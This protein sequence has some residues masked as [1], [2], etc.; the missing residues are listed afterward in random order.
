MAR[1]PMRATPR[2]RAG[3]IVQNALVQVYL[4][5]TVTP[6]IDMFAAA[7]GG[8]AITTLLTNASGE[9]AAY[10]TSAKSV[11]LLVTD[12]SDT[13]FYPSDPGTLK[14]FA[15]FTR[16]VPVPPPP[17]EVVITTDTRTVQLGRLKFPA[18]NVLIGTDALAANTAGTWNTAIGYEALKANTLGT[19]QTA[20]G[21]Q[22]LFSNTTGIANTA[23]GYQALHYN[24]LGSRNTAVGQV[25]LLNLVGNGVVGGDGD[26]NTACGAFAGW[27]VTT[28]TNNTAVG[29]SALCG[30]GGT[31]RLTGDNNT[32]VGT[33]AGIYE[34]GAASHNTGVGQ[35]ALAGA[36]DGTPATGNN[37]SALG[38]RALGLAK[39]AANNVGIGVHSLYEPD[40]IGDTTR[41]TLDG[42]GNTAVGN[43][44]GASNTSDPSYLTAL[45]YR[46]TALGYGTALGANTEASAAG[47]VALGCDNA[48][49]GA[50]TS[51]ANEIKVGTTLHTVNFAGD[52]PVKF[53]SASAAQTTVGAAGAASALPAT[54]T[55]YFKV[56]DSAGTTLVIPAYAA[57]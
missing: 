26:S 9:V 1:S 19:H 4:A 37:N 10:F 27:G 6:V 56:K 7:V 25:A 47:S 33:D 34:S 3:N 12:N 53:N 51:V 54:P 15:P 16:T 39:A 48:G 44:T 45:G 23:L 17:D 21:F 35:G 11:D 13:A 43:F 22:A 40:S 5:G 36:S 50:T 41:A 55:K 52:L 42:V 8:L 30:N 38:L 46:A 49:T 29:Y 2:D 32:M 18:T 57:A 20:L 31:I 28:G 24:V 14:S